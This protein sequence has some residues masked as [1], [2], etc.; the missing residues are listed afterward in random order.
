MTR[1]GFFPA[2]AMPDRKWWTT[3]WPDP[4]S[5]LRSLGIQPGMTVIDLCCGDGYFTTA[6]AK[7]V[8]G[9]VYALDIDPTMLELA[10]AEVA[11]CGASVAAWICGDAR[12]LAGL[13]L[14]PVDYVLIANT[15]H[16]V[17]DRLGLARA[18]AEVLDRD[19]SFAIVN[20]HQ[21]PREQTTVQGEP[22]GPRTDLRM[23]PEQV[24]AA[25]EPAGF[26][27]ARVVELPPYH[28]GA[29]FLRSGPPAP[30]DA[31]E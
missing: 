2:T 12:D 9:R 4:D 5:V 17:P 1:A 20:W 3:L 27:L 24:R 31:D 10:R 22:R 19:G 6:L 26:R 7:I 21:L 29:I 13:V 11:R 8:G 14:K 15:F 23:S 16:G 18:V 28:Y 30:A 25:V